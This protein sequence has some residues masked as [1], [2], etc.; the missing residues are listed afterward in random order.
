[1][2]QDEDVI[3]EGQAARFELNRLRAERNESLFCY[4]T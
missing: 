1:M 2:L 4:D 3:G